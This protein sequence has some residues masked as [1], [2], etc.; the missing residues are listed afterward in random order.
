[1]ADGSTKDLLV[2]LDRGLALEPMAARLREHRNAAGE[3]RD[4]GRSHLLELAT[5][6][7]SVMRLPQPP[8]SSAQRHA[9]V[10][11]LRDAWELLCV[12]GLECHDARADVV[13]AVVDTLNE[14]ERESLSESPNHNPWAC[15]V[16]LVEPDY[17]GDSEGYHECSSYSAF[18]AEVVAE[19]SR[20]W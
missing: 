1:M 20:R 7:V 9:I 10:V 19:I 5:K 11:H 17:D 14:F 15:D 18:G 2:A 16:G 3:A 8:A 12:P 6:R 13:R 4:R